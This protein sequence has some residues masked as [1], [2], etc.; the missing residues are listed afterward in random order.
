MVVV[1]VTGVG[2]TGKTSTAKLLAKQ[3]KYELV[4]LNEL[5]EELKAYT[6]YDRKRRSKIVDMKKLKVAVK[7]LA[8]DAAKMKKSLIIEG[9]FAH[10][11]P[12]DV[13][14]V[15]RCNP[16]ILER[17]LKRKHNWTTK[18][19]ENVEAEMIGIITDEALEKN[20][21]V[22]EIDTTKKTAKETV[23]QVKK[24]LIGKGEKYRVR[25]SV[26]KIDWLKIFD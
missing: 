15:L 22:Y 18:I 6:G 9:L 13:I 7:K 10:E 4:V 14:I 2:G 5:A 25:Q 3:L 12:A 19:H 1:A 8:K 16:K 21:K 24:V 20:K 26:G 11:F 17:R 23:A